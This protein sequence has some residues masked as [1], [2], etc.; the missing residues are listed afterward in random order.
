MK[1]IFLALVLFVGALSLKAQDYKVETVI[2]AMGQDNPDMTELKNLIDKADNGKLKKLSDYHYAKG[3]VYLQIA[4]SDN[5]QNLDPEGM[6]SYVAISNFTESLK[7]YKETG[8]GKYTKNIFDNRLLVNAA[9]G[10]LN[11]A[12]TFYNEGNNLLNAGDTTKAYG[13]LKEAKK[14][15]D[16]IIA[17][18]EYDP[19]ERILKDGNVKEL[20]KQ[21]LIF[22]QAQLSIVMSD[23]VEAKKYLNILKADKKYKE[24]TVFSQLAFIHLADKDTTLALSVVAEGR[25][26]FPENKDLQNI[27]LDIYTK[28]GKMDV[29]L[30]KFKLALETDPENVVY[31]F[32]RGVIYDGKARDAF[33]K[34]RALN[35]TIYNL[36]VKA[37]GEKVAAKKTQI[38]KAYND[39]KAQQDSLYNLCKLY[40]D[41]SIIDYKKIEEIDPSNFDAVFNYGVVIFNYKA[42]ILI[43]RLNNLDDKSPKYNANYEAIKKELTAVLNESLE[44]FRRAREIKP[45]DCSVL[46]AIQKNYAQLGNEKKTT[47][48]KGIAES[49][50][51]K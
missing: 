41:S 18:H 50:G 1:K 23:Y 21:S 40:N 31:L 24:P 2:I 32:N 35:D 33:D 43:D 49:F 28:Q 26:M 42:G 47:E 17:A 29:L 27:E 16:V 14:F 12:I 37:R 7:Q 34:G 44:I 20:A 39:F 36:M 48:F 3:L 45:S 9:I 51:C 22:N 15:F 46:G 8:K 11:K 19:E 4:I 25:E 30:D 10:C 13:K 5:L 6:A 38:L